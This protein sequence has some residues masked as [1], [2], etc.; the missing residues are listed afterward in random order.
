[1]YDEKSSNSWQFLPC[2]S[3][4]TI[5]NELYQIKARCNITDTAYIISTY[6]RTTVVFVRLTSK[7]VWAGEP[8]A[9]GQNCA[10]CFVIAQVVCPFL[11][12]G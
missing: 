9:I 1:M 2:E 10:L 5:T 7:Q 12:R 4:V 3:K 8:Y 6:K 11:K